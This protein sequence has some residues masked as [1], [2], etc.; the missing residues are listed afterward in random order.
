MSDIRI[1]LAD[2]HA[3]VREGLK[4]LINAHSGMK[5]VG[6]AADGLEAV[7]LAAEL[8]PDVVVVDVSMPALNGA[9][10]TTRLREM[11]PDRKVLALTVHE[12]VGYLRLLLEA[13][14]VGYVL[15]RAA[16]SE[17]VQAIRVVAEGKTYLD[18]TVAGNVVGGFVNSP[19][20]QECTAELSERETEVLQLI[21]LGY[22][23]KE[24]G[25]RLKL[26]VKTV[27]TYKTRSME[28]LGLHGRVD[29][30]QYA[31][32]RGWLKTA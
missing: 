17:L 20:E 29:I 10:V 7:K 2:D 25:S 5:V 16:V 30:V 6:E 24:I 31:A 9:Q 4:S 28:K 15:K 8:D 11:R 18:P 12:D 13:G 19:L 22:S 1:L 26:S 3:V 21:A 32:R 23:N 27:E 14:A